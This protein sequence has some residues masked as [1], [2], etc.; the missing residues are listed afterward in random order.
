[1][2]EWLGWHFLPG[3]GKTAHRNRRTVVAGKTYSC[4]GPLVLCENGMHASKRA[5]GR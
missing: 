5:L 1:M 3:D 2:N 4:R